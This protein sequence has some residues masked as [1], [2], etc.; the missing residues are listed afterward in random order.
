MKVRL[1]TSRGGVRLVGYPDVRKVLDENGSVLLD[2]DN[3]P[4]E[5]EYERFQEEGFAQNAGD[6]IDVGADEAKRLID[7]GQAVAVK[8]SAPKR[9]R[10]PKAEKAEAKPKA[11]NAEAKP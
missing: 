1:L 6:V 4:V 5:E 10:K 9:E 2:D 8:E 11:E 3:N 7:D